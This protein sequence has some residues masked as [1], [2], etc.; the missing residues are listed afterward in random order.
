MLR[1]NC[2]HVGRI[3]NSFTITTT[4]SFEHGRYYIGYRPTYGY[5]N[6]IFIAHTAVCDGQAQNN[7]NDVGKNTE[8]GTAEMQ[9]NLLPKCRERRGCDGAS[10]LP[11][12]VSH[13]G[14]ALARM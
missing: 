3:Y 8:K 14:C 5:T 7:G 6:S 12:L 10:L 11:R 4:C 9:D 13:G 2:V 1:Q